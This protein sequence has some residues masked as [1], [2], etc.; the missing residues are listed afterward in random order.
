MVSIRRS[1]R[2]MQFGIVCSIGFAWCMSSNVV[3]AG[4]IGGGGGPPPPPPP[5]TQAAAPPT[6]GSPS[7]GGS[8]DAGGGNAPVTTGSDNGFSV[9]GGYSVAPSNANGGGP[10][11]I[12]FEVFEQ[13]N[14]NTTAQ[15]ELGM[16]L[17]SYFYDSLGDKNISV[18]FT[19]DAN[20]SDAGNASL[21][22]V[23]LQLNGQL[24]GATSEANA[25]TLSGVN[26]SDLFTLNKGDL[27]TLSFTTTVQYD[28]TLGGIPSN[29]VITFD[30]P[31]NG[32]L[33]AV[34]E[35]S[36]CALLGL[37][38]IGLAIGAYRR[39]RAQAVA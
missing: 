17:F 7:F 12:S 1:L 3:L 21:A 35:P 28:S 11:T 9:S 38:A 24:T 15:Y 37:G 22:H 39:R 20:V 32:S 36:S 34:P 26:F 19:G 13:L 5:P 23:H 30:L 4:T 31:N 6:T 16:G 33:N 29:D 2:F 27:V 10:P 14:V 18:T 25:L 8:T